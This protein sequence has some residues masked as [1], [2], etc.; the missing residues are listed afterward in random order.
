MGGA[1]L[2]ETR[3]NHRERDKIRERERERERESKRAP[4]P[5][6]VAVCPFLALL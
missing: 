5:A 2:L 1:S 6:L 3:V 4:H